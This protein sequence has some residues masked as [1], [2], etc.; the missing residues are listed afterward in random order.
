MSTNWIVIME[1]VVPKSSSME[2]KIYIQRVKGLASRPYCPVLLHYL[3]LDFVLVQTRRPCSLI[4][5]TLEVYP[6]GRKAGLG[7]YEGCRIRYRE[8]L[9]YT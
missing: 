1:G 7:L 5:P 8:E 9:L 4:S 3:G 2:I 6:S